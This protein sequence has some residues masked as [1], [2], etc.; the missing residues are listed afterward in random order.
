MYGTKVLNESC[1]KVQNDPENDSY[2]WNLLIQPGKLAFIGVRYEEKVKVPKFRTA[3][4]EISF[5]NFENFLKYFKG[6]ISYMKNLAE[7]L[8]KVEMSKGFS[9]KSIFDQKNQ[10]VGTWMGHVEANDSH[11]LKSYCFFDPSRM[12]QFS[13]LIEAF[14][15][16]KE[17]ECKYLL[18][19]DP[20]LVRITTTSGQEINAIRMKRMEFTFPHWMELLSKDVKLLHNFCKDIL[21]CMKGFKKADYAHSDI[22]CP[23]I[24]FLFF[25]LHFLVFFLKFLSKSCIFPKSRKP[26]QDIEV[27]FDRL[28]FF[29]ARCIYFSWIHHSIIYR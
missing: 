20:E 29:T 24:G 10:C 17:E 7:N 9:L 4:C 25:F 22:R 26:N 28:G 15:N 23:N 5:T 27:Y 8:P 16:S 11:I 3:Y 13:S 12:N 19:L 2:F 6:F 1:Q 14:M 21:K 18:E